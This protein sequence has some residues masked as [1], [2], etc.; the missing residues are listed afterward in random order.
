MNEKLIYEFN[1]SACLEIQ[2]P[3]SKWYRVTS[4]EFRA[5]SYPRRILKENKYEEYIGPIYYYGTNFKVEKINKDGIQ[6]VNDVDPR[7]LYKKTRA[8]G[9]I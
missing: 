6:F 3:N 9:R 5:Y 2:L 8:Y 7:T 4:G 1:A